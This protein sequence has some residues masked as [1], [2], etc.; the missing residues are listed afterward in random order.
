MKVEHGAS[1]NLSYILAGCLMS[2]VGG[3]FQLLVFVKSS[4]R[5]L[6]GKVGDTNCKIVVEHSQN[7]TFSHQE[8]RN[9]VAALIE[10]RQENRTE[11]VVQ[12]K[13]E[14]EVE[15]ESESRD[16][17]NLKNVR[18][19]VDVVTEDNIEEEGEES[20]ISGAENLRKKRSKFDVVVED[21]LDDVNE[22]IKSNSKRKRRKAEVLIEDKIDDDEEEANDNSE[23][24]RSKLDVE[25]GEMDLDK[26]R[27]AENLKKKTKKISKEKEEEIHNNDKV[28]QEI[29]NEILDYGKE[30]S[31]KHCDKTFTH[32]QSLWLHKKTH[33]NRK[34]E[35]SPHHDSDAKH[36][37][38]DNAGKAKETDK[39][40]KV[41]EVL[42][43]VDVPTLEEGADVEEVN[44]D[45]EQKV[46]SK[47]SKT[48]KGN[49]QDHTLEEG[50]AFDDLS[51]ADQRV[52]SKKNKKGND[53]RAADKEDGL[54]SK[55]NLFEDEEYDSENVLKTVKKKMKMESTAKKIFVDETEDHGPKKNSKR[56]SS[57]IKIIAET[58]DTNEEAVQVENK[59]MMTKESI[60]M[61]SE[62][63]NLHSQVDMKYPWL[64]FIEIIL[65][66][67]G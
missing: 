31:C 58:A 61:D 25:E 11:V 53:Q 19:K 49:N 32:S 60:V 38:I 62:Y 30:Y 51:E 10:E 56:E 54:N 4:L 64:E 67:G 42:V 13:I 46:G 14:E 66:V 44:G 17:D 35:R 41:V 43:E 7:V 20:K 40:E 18:S 16:S 8:E 37:Q 26:A 9:V 6:M 23:R 39:H 2:K 34:R 24:K 1:G 3:S 15:E 63:F 45:Q 59:N 36:V 27:E 65:I 57:A 29:E 5:V 50:A 55:K 28:I 21:K 52:R 22:E 12:D 33:K 48:K 47:K